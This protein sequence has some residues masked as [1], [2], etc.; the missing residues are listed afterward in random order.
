MDRPDEQCLLLLVDRM[1]HRSAIPPRPRTHSSRA[2]EYQRPPV[3]RDTPSSDGSRSGRSAAMVPC[4]PQHHLQVDFHKRFAAPPAPPSS[5]ASVRGVRPS[6]SARMHAARES[7]PDMSAPAAAMAALRKTRGVGVDLSEF[8]A[9]AQPILV[10]NSFEEIMG[11]FHTEGEIFSSLSLCAEV[12]YNET[13]EVTRQL[14]A[15]NPLRTAVACYLLD[16][17]TPSGPGSTSY[18]PLLAA[19]KDDVFASIYANSAATPRITG[20]IAATPEEQRSAGVTHLLNNSTY[21]QDYHGEVRARKALQSEYDEQM[22]IAE[23]QKVVLS[24]VIDRWQLMLVD[25]L[26]TAWRTFA[27]SRD[28]RL[29]RSGA[30]LIRATNRRRLVEVFD[31]W[32]EYTRDSVEERL[33]NEVRELRAELARA[34]DDADADRAELVADFEASR[35]ACTSLEEQLL[36]VKDELRSAQVALEQRDIRIKELSAQKQWWRAAA[37]RAIATSAP[38]DRLLRLPEDV[39]INSFT[40]SVENGGFAASRSTAVVE[41]A[42]DTTNTYF[43]AMNND[44]SEQGSMAVHTAA[45]L[46][47]GSTDSGTGF[48]RVEDLPQSNPFRGLLVSLPPSLQRAVTGFHSPAAVFGLPA[49]LLIVGWVNYVARQSRLWDRLNSAHDAQRQRSKEGDATLGTDDVANTVLG[50]VCGAQVQQVSPARNLSGD[51]ASGDILLLLAEALG[52]FVFDD[53]PVASASTSPSKSAQATPA[54]ARARPADVTFAAPSVGARID[55]I[56]AAEPTEAEAEALLDHLTGFAITA[57]ANAKVAVALD[58]LFHRTMGIGVSTPCPVDVFAVCT[59]SAAPTLLA[60]LGALMKCYTALAFDVTRAPSSARSV[61]FVKGRNRRMPRDASGTMLDVAYDAAQCREALRLLHGAAAGDID[62][63]CVLEADSD[64]R[65]VVRHY[66]ERLHLYEVKWGWIGAA[67]D[68]R[69]GVNARSPQSEAAIGASHAKLEHDLDPSSSTVEEL[70]ANSTFVAA[71]LERARSQTLRLMSSSMAASARVRRDFSSEA[72]LPEGVVDEPTDDHGEEIAALCETLLSRPHKLRDVF[73]SYGVAQ[74]AGPRMDHGRFQQFLADH[75]LYSQRHLPKKHAASLYEALIELCSAARVWAPM[76]T[77]DPASVSFDAA[78]GESPQDGGLTPPNASI[79]DADQHTHDI[80]FQ[81]W[82]AALVYVAASAAVYE[83]QVA[84]TKVVSQ[85]SAQSGKPPPAFLPTALQKLRTLLN[86][87]TTM[88]AT[89]TIHEVRATMYTK[90]VQAVLAQ[91]NQTL[92]R[93]FSLAAG[94]D[95]DPEMSLDEFM[96]VMS[97]TRLDAAV[98]VPVLHN[99]FKFFGGP[100]ESMMYRDFLEALVVVVQHVDP[101]PLTPLADRVKAFLR[102][103]GEG[104]FLTTALGA[105]TLRKRK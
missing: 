15:P 9:H 51:M 55:D 54:K 96:R 78:H 53:V 84:K 90:D 25:R 93:I 75:Q 29:A 36:H 52:C 61:A 45:S 87:L 58:A 38:A 21:Y 44:S 99:I 104:A 103:R 13:L 101:S 88:S 49:E 74:G 30:G 69:V 17:L 27:S 89:S 50:L 5:V 80:G 83:C 2:R 57:T 32:R 94:A 81:Q 59:G 23:K 40:P 70:A 73:A 43:A 86:A 97:V 48:E 63:D 19:L 8:P 24:R 47:F 82:T 10:K 16:R 42:S 34:G 28:P 35:T 91:Y 85:Y 12:A 71:M 67:V 4:S 20:D 79:G 14:S 76:S 56:A 1:D 102:K 65:D 39:L 92:A 64:E 62:G 37:L 77:D 66:L 60:F 31:R 95:S 33:L 11:R 46:F 18:S 68:D 105:L 3:V 41:T 72:S 26:F 6:S 22:L 98:T 100:D 7:Q